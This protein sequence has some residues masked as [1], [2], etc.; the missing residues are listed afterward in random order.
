M[1]KIY[2]EAEGEESG[3]IGEDAL[4]MKKPTGCNVL[5]GFLFF[6]VYPTRQILNCT[7]VGATVYVTFK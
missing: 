3:S 6:V 4:D 7:I 5:V 1:R 2:A